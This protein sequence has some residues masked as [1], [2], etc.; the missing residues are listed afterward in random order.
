MGVFSPVCPQTYFRT[1]SSSARTKMKTSGDLMSAQ[2]RKYVHET[3]KIHN[4][5]NF[6]KIRSNALFEPLSS[7]ATL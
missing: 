2:E 4:Y 7:R 1:R 6:R 5:R 3:A